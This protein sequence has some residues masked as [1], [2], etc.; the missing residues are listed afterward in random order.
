M[1]INLFK[2]IRRGSS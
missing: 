1:Q 2:F